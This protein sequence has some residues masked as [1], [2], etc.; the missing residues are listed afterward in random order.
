M[1]TNKN[2]LKIIMIAFL[3]AGSLLAW[4]APAA[5]ST[6]GETARTAPPLLV[7]QAGPE[8][9]LVLGGSYSLEEGDR[10]DG[11]LFILGGAASLAPGSTVIGDVVLLGGS[12][13]ADGRIQGSI[14]ALGGVLELSETSVVEGDVN[15][16]GSTVSGENQATIQGEIHSEEISAL[17]I[18]IPSG[19]RFPFP[20]VQVHFNPF[21][22]L[23]WTLFQSLL[24]AAA[25][26]LVALILPQA[27][28]RVG[29]TFV[30]QP[31][32]SGGL[33]LLTAV[34]APLV[35]V[36]MAITI[37]GIP[38]VVL[39]AIALVVVW[40]YGMIAIGVEVGQRLAQMGK[41]DWALAVSAALGT[42][43]LTVVVNGVGNFVPCVG[44]I[45][46][47]LVGVLGVGAVLLTRFGTRAFPDIVTQQAPDQ[48]GPAA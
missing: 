17:P 41:A 12:L 22:E 18:V 29:R 13:E 7:V 21:W 10:L 46:P 35:M 31:L 16:L 14:S 48:P 36:L 28:Q 15:I 32:V 19:L 39:L 24:W 38:L 33:G 4:V 23:F 40:A 37:I 43:L 11:S 27:V 25:A 9:K 44:W 47:F 34:V 30:T 6:G 2:L 3:L 42:F 20:D 8:T 5:A 1:K 45:V 26:A